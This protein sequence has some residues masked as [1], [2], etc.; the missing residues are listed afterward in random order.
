MT[1]DTALS[2]EHYLD[3]GGSDSGRILFTI[4][5]LSSKFNFILKRNVI[6]IKCQRSKCRSYTLKQ[7][8]IAKN[9]QLF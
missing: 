6:V 9:S 1:P 7:Y 4:H 2:K 8:V 5:I 3:I